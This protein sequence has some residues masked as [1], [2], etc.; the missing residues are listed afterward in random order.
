MLEYYQSV[1]IL[2]TNKTRDIDAAFESRIDMILTYKQLDQQA[3]RQIWAHFINRL[4]P[5]CTNLSQRDLDRL[6]RW[7]INGRQIKNSV[8]TA[9]IIAIKQNVPLSISHLN[10]V[11][12]VRKDG[13][14][15]IGGQEG[16]WNKTQSQ[17]WF[18]WIHWLWAR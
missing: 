7:A 3:R 2:T 1:L 18:G 4:L 11:L 5:V 10:I 17:K 15:L 8:K 13:S 14:K 6:S 9:R 16:Q 12:K